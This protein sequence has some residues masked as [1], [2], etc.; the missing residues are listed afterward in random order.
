MPVLLWQACTA[1]NFGGRYCLL[2]FVLFKLIQVSIPTWANSKVN[3]SAE[4][5]NGRFLKKLTAKLRPL[6]PQAVYPCVLFE[7]PLLQYMLDHQMG[8]WVDCSAGT[9]YVSV[10]LC[11]PLYGIRGVTM[12]YLCVNAFTSLHMAFVVGLLFLIC[13]I[14]TQPYT[15]STMCNREESNCVR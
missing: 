6:R 15:I 2:V 4:F 10:P 13:I 7:N 9:V 12:L 5:H 1:P 14:L 11:Y 3:S 8:G